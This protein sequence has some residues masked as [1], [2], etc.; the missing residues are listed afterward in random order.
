[1][2]SGRLAAPATQTTA[3][4]SSRSPVSSRTVIGRHLRHA[5]AAANL[6]AARAR[7]VLD[8]PRGAAGIAGQDGRPVLEQQRCDVAHA[9][10]LEARL[11]REGQ[12]DAAG[13]RAHHDH[14]RPVAP[15]Q[16]GDQVLRARTSSAMGRVGSACSRTPGRSRPLTV[17]PTSNDAV[18]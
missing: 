18:S 15:A 3:S 2:K 10:A 11:K 8:P 5:R 1:M 9:L 16:R 13:A 6:D 12:L 17:E 7:I 4:A 14:A